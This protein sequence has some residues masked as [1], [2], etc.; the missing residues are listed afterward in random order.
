M[1]NIKVKTAQ[2]YKSSHVCDGTLKG[3]LRAGFPFNVIDV[4]HQGDFPRHGHEY[5]ELNIVIGGSAVHVTE[6]ESYEIEE[7]DVFV[8]SGEHQHAFEYCS[9]LR[10]AIVQFSPHVRGMID[11]SF[12][13]LRNIFGYRRIAMGGISGINQS[14]KKLQPVCPRSCK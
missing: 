12:L 2:G 1:K 4:V 5:S 14:V 7:G 11:A 6:Y 3:D 8:I 9:N 10:L 13:L